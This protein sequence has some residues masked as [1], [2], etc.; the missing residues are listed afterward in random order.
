MNLSDE[1]DYV[2]PEDRAAGTTLR[3]FGPAW[4]APLCTADR[5]VF[6][7]ANVSCVLCGLP[8]GPDDSGV[9]LPY[10]GMAAPARSRWSH[11][12]LTCFTEIIT[13]SDHH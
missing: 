8:I 7:P 6:L 3:W 13:A 10:M 1:L 12:D 11:Y 9:R 5:Q 4:G 2:H